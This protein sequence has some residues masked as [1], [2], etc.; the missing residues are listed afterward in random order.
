M[1]EKLSSFAQDSHASVE[2]QA[3][4]GLGRLGL[5]ERIA[6]STGIALELERIYGEDFTEMVLLDSLHDPSDLPPELRNK[7]EVLL[8][9]AVRGMGYEV[10]PVPG[11]N[12]TDAGSKE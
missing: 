7:I 4:E 3:S 2:T 6:L 11:E 8:V 1:V 12:T 10:T 5:D 9:D